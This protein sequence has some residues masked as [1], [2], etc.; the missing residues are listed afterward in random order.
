MALMR[1]LQKDTIAKNTKPL[2]R[3]NKKQRKQLLAMDY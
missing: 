2:P 3:Q 1:L